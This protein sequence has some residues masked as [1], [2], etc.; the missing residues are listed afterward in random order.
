ML[1]IGGCPIAFPLQI[2]Y[3]RRRQQIS[4][5]DTNSPKRVLTSTSTPPPPNQTYVPSQAPTMPLHTGHT[6]IGYCTLRNGTQPSANMGS[7]ISMVSLHLQLRIEN[8]IGE[9]AQLSMTPVTR[10][11]KVGVKNIMNFP[12]FYFSFAFSFSPFSM[13]KL[14]MSE[15]LY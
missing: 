12:V 9:L 5:I 14:Q 3:I 7:S 15:N 1:I 2:D 10:S 8:L 4:T 6:P 13:Q 11:E